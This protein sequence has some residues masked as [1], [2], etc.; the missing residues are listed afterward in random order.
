MLLRESASHNAATPKHADHIVK[1]ASANSTPSELPS[2]TA[3]DASHQI[4]NP[5]CRASSVSKKVDRVPW[6]SRDAMV[7][8]PS[9]DREGADKREC[10]TTFLE[11][12]LD[13]RWEVPRLPEPRASARAVLPRPTPS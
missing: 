11:T 6:G 2:K 10:G 8:F 7:T 12:V 1:N 3:A 4:R 9:R 13:R 5:R